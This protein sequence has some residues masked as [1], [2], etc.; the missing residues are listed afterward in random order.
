[1]TPAYAALVTPARPTAQLW[2]IALGL[3]LVAVIYTLWMLGM[4]GALWLSAGTDALEGQL[5][6]IATASDPWSVIL[7]LGTFVGAWLGL[8]LVMR[9][10]HGRPIGAVIGRAAPV[11]RDFMLG[12]AAMVVVGGL[13]TLAMLPMMP[14]LALSAEPR[15]W[16]MFLPLA[17]LGVLVQTG[18]EEA[19]FR[20]YLQTHL[21]ARFRAPLVWMGVP[22]LL[23]GLAHYSPEAAGGNL[24]LIVLATGLFGL[25]ASDLTARTGNLGIAWGLHFANNVMVILILSVSGTLD[26]LALFRAAN[27]DLEASAL[28]GLILA[29]M[30]V[31]L[32]VWAACRLWL[33][34]R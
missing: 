30:A 26:G 11:L 13:L 8:W 27:G 16:L 3:G 15:V 21:A 32:I 33:R 2:R 34:R 14:P 9:V 20:G 18:A 4:G 6:G 19:V 12:L 23:F 29:D 24:W 7:L 10:L 28:Q 17:L 1:M 25:I 31:L 5:A 22:T